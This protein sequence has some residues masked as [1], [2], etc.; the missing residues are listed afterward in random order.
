MFKYSIKYNVYTGDKPPQE[1]ISEETTA[2][3]M[4][5]QGLKKILEAKHGAKIS[6]ISWKEVIETVG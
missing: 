4:D 6:L 2:Q 3:H 1:K 5:E